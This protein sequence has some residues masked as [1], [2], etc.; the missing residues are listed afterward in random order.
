MI[1]MWTMHLPKMVKAKEHELR[2][3]ILFI[4][5]KMNITAQMDSRGLFMA[6]MI[7]AKGRQLMIPRI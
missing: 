1:V 5:P 6:V 2:N 4:S 3:N 7:K